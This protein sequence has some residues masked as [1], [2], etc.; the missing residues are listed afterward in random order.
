MQSPIEKVIHNNKILAIIVRAR[1][2][3]ELDSS[4]EKM[5][6]VTPEDFPLQVA[7]HSRQQG[8]MVKPHVHLPFPELKNLPV[9]EFFY[10]ISGKVKIDLFDEREDDARVS[11]VTLEEGDVIVLNTGH[12]FTFLE[13]AKL[14][15][16]KQG[17]Y[18]GREREK[19][20]LEKEKTEPVHNDSSL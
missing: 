3:Q 17:P 1:A 8:D 11:E 14:I 4:P 19:R 2:L 13:E 10:L 16:L 12:S 7:I 6:F 9:Q 15:E 18:R 5:L 20:F